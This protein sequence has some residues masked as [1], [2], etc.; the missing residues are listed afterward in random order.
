[1]ARI[2]IVDDEPDV[3]RLAVA[4]LAGRGHE[5]ITAADGAA[6][7]D[8]AAA[9]AFDLAIVDRNLPQIDGLEVCRRL[10]AGARA[11]PVVML[12]AGPIELEEA[13]RADG[14]SAFVVRPLLRETLVGNVERLLAGPV[15]GAPS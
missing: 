3:V 4:A 15:A 9:E 2:L 7:L 10:R 13:C 11:V 5:V 1:M 6:A 14:P 8:L 12:S